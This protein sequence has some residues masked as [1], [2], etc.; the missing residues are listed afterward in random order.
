MKTLLHIII[1]L[2]FS[3]S[4]FAQVDTVK[5]TA[6][7]TSFYTPLEQKIKEQIIISEKNEI[8]K[9]TKFHGHWNGFGL[10]IN[11]YMNK[12]GSFTLPKEAD[13]MS[14]RTSRS[15]NV[16]LNPWKV[17]FGLIK[18]RLG[19][20]S[21]IGVE[22]NNYFFANDNNILRDSTGNIAEE[23]LTGTGIYLKRSKLTSMYLTIPLLLEFNM[24]FSGK[25][26]AHIS[27]GVVGSMLI[28]SHT[29]AVYTKD[30]SKIKDKDWGNKN[31]NF[32]TYGVTARIGY[33]DVAIYG[34]YYPV[35]LFQKG[36]GPEL[37]P[38]NIGFLWSLFH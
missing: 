35:S 29:K 12:D 4:G 15:L 31:L 9:K 21:G 19:V 13:Y 38:I 32:F 3:I 24:R 30:G 1:L 18:D 20:V 37:Y 10:G 27:A 22:W 14:L 33:G 7:D 25:H 8:R 5:V 26:R 36:K 17:D 2:S 23:K 6:T 28:S 16:V 34:T 11:N